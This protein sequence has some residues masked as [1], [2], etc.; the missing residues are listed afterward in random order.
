MIVAGGQD[1]ALVQPLHYHIQ[2]NTLKRPLENLPDDRGRVL[3]DQQAVAVVRV[4][5]VAVGRTRPHKLPV[6][7][8]LILL[9]PDLLADVGGVSLV[10]HIFQRDNQ[11]ISAVFNVLAVKLVVDGNKPYTMEREILLSKFSLENI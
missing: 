7:H 11:V 3:V 2:R 6:P 9:C 5:P 4:L 1:A 8:G 10:Y